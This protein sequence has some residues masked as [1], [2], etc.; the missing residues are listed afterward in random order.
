M[1]RFKRN[2]FRVGSILLLTCFFLGLGA[3]QALAGF[4][5]SPPSL[6]NNHLLPGS[7]YEQLIYLVRG[8]P[9][10]TLFT[11]IKINAPEIESWIK[12]EPGLEFDLPEGVQQFPVKFVVDVPE[13]AEFKLYEGTISIL[14]SASKMSQG[15]VAVA[16]GAEAKISLNVS[17]EEFSGF[18]F[19]GASLG[20]TGK[21]SP[22]KLTL[23]IENKGNQDIGLIRAHLMV[24][25][26][27]HRSLLEEH[28]ADV[29]ANIEPFK[30]QEIS[31]EFPTDLGIGQYW[32]DFK[33]YKGDRLIEKDEQ[34]FNIL[35]KTVITATEKQGNGEESGTEETVREF[36]YL[37]VGIVIVSG[38]IFW[39]F[40]RKKIV[41]S[42]K[43][44]RRK[45]AAR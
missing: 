27:Y 21:G 28:E 16:L 11:T 8:E 5:I 29:S 33:V 45:R 44:S 37:A 42:K 7:H 36:P 22:I 15:Q 40:L 38:L 12:V 2:S 9:K 26:K 23:K 13:D 31:I 6:T 1:K 17:R 39:F 43:P 25:D 19:R 4:G 34:V 41:S 18:V 14:N 32:G 30:T 10:E 3:S 20:N 35:E 24:F